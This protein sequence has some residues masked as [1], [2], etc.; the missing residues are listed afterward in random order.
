M[1]TEH[2]EIFF[3]AANQFNCWIGLREPNKLADKWIAKPGFSP[4]GLNCKAKTADNEIHK[5]S[6]LVVNPFL[7]PDA[8]KS[9]TLNEAKEKWTTKFFLNGKPPIGFVCIETGQDRGLVKYLNNALYAD[10]DLMSLT[11]SDEIG[12]MVFTDEQSQK[13]FRRS[14]KI[15][16]SSTEGS[17]NTA[18]PRDVVQGNRPVET[19]VSLFLRP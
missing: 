15:F 4:K 6:G 1:K 12:G 14:K 7:C 19:G 8:F 3:K 17:T 2:K 13:T 16:K 18:R 5:L 9:A 11:S 10:F